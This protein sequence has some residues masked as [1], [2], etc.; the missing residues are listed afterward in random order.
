MKRVL[1]GRGGRT[2]KYDSRCDAVLQL[3]L[4]A[5]FTALIAW[6]FTKPTFS[7]R[8]STV[9]NMTQIWVAIWTTVALLWI[10]NLYRAGEAFGTCSSR[11]PGT[12]KLVRVVEVMHDPRPILQ[13]L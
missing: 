6:M 3:V 7:P 1:V 13:L 2:S 9:P 4:N 8:T 10:R 12:A 5:A 11:S